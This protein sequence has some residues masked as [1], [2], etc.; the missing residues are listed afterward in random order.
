MNGQAILGRV[1][2][3]VWLLAIA[4]GAAAIVA[5]AAWP[6]PIPQTTF[7]ISTGAIVSMAILGVVWASIGAILVVRRAGGPIG[8]LMVV[9]GIGAAVTALLS[10]VTFAA[11]AE[12]TP[13]AD[14]IASIAAELIVGFNVFLVLMGYI[15]FIFPTG[16]AL[17]ER[18]NLV[19]RLYLVVG[20]SLS[21]I[22]F[23]QP[24]G[25]ALTPGI[26]NPIGFGPD[27]Q[28]ILGDQVTSRLDAIV[29]A[30]GTVLIVPAVWARYRVA[31]HTERQQLKWF[32]LAAAITAG[33][34]V[35]TAVLSAVTT[36]P[37][38]RTPLVAMTIAGMTIPVAIGVAIL[39]YHLYDIDRVISR[40]LAYIV[41]TGLLLGAYA[42]IVL[43]LGGPLAG[44]TGGDTISVAL[45]TLIVAALF[46]PLRGRVQAIVDRRFDRARIDADRTSAAFSERLRDE[47]DMD[48]LTADLGETVRTSVRPDRIGV[49]LRT[50]SRDSAHATNP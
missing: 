39:R 3:I 30:I 37:I 38:D 25:A 4:V 12:G 50:P 9:I 20:F 45:S 27:L 40:T 29:A 46:Q 34:V 15:P 42:V 41:I 22:Q 35:A 28:P 23:I 13:R 16:R 48:T 49:W 47:V 11:F 21:A 33:A 8:R 26:P 24:G 10:S 1:M 6:A 32:G 7:G 36:G 2:I 19:A 18:W 5:R 17:S 43:L 44:V 31:N 14:S